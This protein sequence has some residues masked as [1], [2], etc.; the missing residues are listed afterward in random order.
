M[1][2]YVVVDHQHTVIETGFASRKEAKQ[3][4]SDFR[5]FYHCRLPSVLATS[6]PLKPGE[7]V[8]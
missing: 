2:K 4:A 5:K 3:F 6:L 1:E 7:K 8:A